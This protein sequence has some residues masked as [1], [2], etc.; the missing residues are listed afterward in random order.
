MIIKYVVPSSRRRG[1]KEG[2][3]GPKMTGDQENTART[4][5]VGHP[6]IEM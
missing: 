1:I 2:R 4:A 5:M 3:T 6:G